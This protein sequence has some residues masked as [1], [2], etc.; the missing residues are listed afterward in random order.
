MKK[1]FILIGFSLLILSCGIKFKYATLSTAGYA[2]GI[3]SSSKTIV[4]PSITKIDTIN[5]FS[6]LRWKLRTDFNFRWDFAQYAMNQPYSWYWN[7]PRLEG[8]WRPYNRFDVYFYS[9]FF[10]TDWAMNY[11]NWGW[12]NWY[13]WYRP[14]YSWNR[15]YN[16]WN[17][18]YNRPNSYYWNNA[19]RNDN[20]YV[21][22]YGRR[23]SL[24]TNYNRSNI[25]NQIITRYDNPRRINNNLD[26]SIKDLR[27][28]GYNVRVYNNLN[29]DQIN[30]LNTRGNFSTESRNNGRGSWSR[31]IVPTGTAGST[32][33]YPVQPRQIRGGSRPSVPQQTRSSV[34]S[35][36]QG[37]SSSGRIQN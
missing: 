22:V 11:G 24:S 21:H 18:W 12:N 33:S 28:R 1:I 19:W 7:N 14:Y 36:S 29:N 13:S 6:D 34:N 31:Q 15:P 16:P 8:I 3:Y 37:R 2:D 35:S 27:E 23:G 26:N 32:I 9:N 10:W 4:V 5:S 20:T 25:S 30:E 17:Y